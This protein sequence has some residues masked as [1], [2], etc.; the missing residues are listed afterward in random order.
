[1]VPRKVSSK[2]CRGFVKGDPLSPLLFVLVME[3][4]SRMVNATIEQG[5]L[6]GFPTGGRV[7]SDLVVS[8]SLFAGETLIFCEAHPQ[9]VRYVHLILLCFEAVSG[10]RV[11]LGK[12]QNCGY[13]SGGRYWGSSYYSWVQYCSFAYEVPRPAF[14][15]IV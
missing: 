3:A 9:Q 5:L 10:L 13:R 1:M 12:S 7:F 6:I 15:G 8:H 11:N 14:R 2:V 4:L